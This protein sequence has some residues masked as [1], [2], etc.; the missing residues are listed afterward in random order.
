MCAYKLTW[1][2]PAA[3]ISERAGHEQAAAAEGTKCTVNAFHLLLKTGSSSDG[4]TNS[5][6]QRLGHA[7]TRMPPCLPQA[8]LFLLLQRQR[9]LALLQLLLLLFEI[10][11]VILQPCAR[12][13]QTRVGSPSRAPVQVMRDMQT[14]CSMR[15]LSFACRHAPEEKQ[16]TMSSITPA[17]LI[18]SCLPGA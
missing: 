11:T 15:R 9:V 2:L 16:Q 8:A 17:A 3:R 1:C 6:I 7:H 10:L 12:R 14:C 18:S 4:A 5:T 13:K